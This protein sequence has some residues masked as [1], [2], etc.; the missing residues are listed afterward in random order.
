[1]LKL[2]AFVTCDRVITDTE[3]QTSLIGLFNELTVVLMDPMAQPPGDAVAARDWAIFTSWE[4]SSEDDGK[5]FHQDI[6]LLYPD[7]T[8]FSPEMDYPFVILADK[9]F[10][11]VI[12]K[13]RG[14]PIGKPGRYTISMK[15]RSN[16]ITIFGPVEIWIDIKYGSAPANPPS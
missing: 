11:N 9:R 6:Q 8:P 15:L 14:F 3:G 2:Y 13:S 5:E 10:Q 16:G 4:K 1:M 7:G 12:A